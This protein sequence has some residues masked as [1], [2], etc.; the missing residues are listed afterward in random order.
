M[1]INF[2]QA[3]DDMITRL[4]SWVDQLI[5]N[6]PN[7]IL[8]IVVFILALILSKYIS[9]LTLRLLE[10]SKLQ[11]SM[12]N[13]IA[14]LVSVL[15]ILSG[16]FLVLGILDLSKTLN[17]I[18]A[19]AGVA[20]LAV[21]LALQGALA[22]TYS[23][24][25]LSYIK[26]IKFGDWIETNDY[27]GEVVDLDLRAVTI[28]QPDNNLVYIPNK[29]VLENAI[30]NFSTTAQSRVILECGVA[31]ESD[32]EFVRD[33]VNK[34]IVKNFDPVESVDD[35]I[36]LYTEFGDSS[37]NFEVRFWIDSTSA[38]EVLKA[39]TEAMIAIKKVFDENDITI[40]FPIRTLDFPKKVV[41][42][43]TEHPN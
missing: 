26:Q 22:N 38:L 16:L 23:G 15:V 40:P 21:G 39:K 12:K 17:A 32:L 34:T 4:E 37:I 2:E 5:I 20:G 10:K 27:E 8:S 9:R 30:K 6:L 42:G 28:K 14:K 33:L 11:A 41:V 25:V 3:W 18:L 19:G 13:V 1:N 43:T 31:Y 7:I 35:I 24:I 29:L 36:F